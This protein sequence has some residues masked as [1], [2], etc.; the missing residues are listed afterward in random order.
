MNR[1][2]TETHIQL[3][4]SVGDGK[5]TPLIATEDLSGCLF[6][7]H[8]M[9]G[10]LGSLRCGFEVLT[11]RLGCRVK[12]LLAVLIE[13]LNEDE[14]GFTPNAFTFMSG[15]WEER[16]VGIKMFLILRGC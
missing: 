13:I 5:V 16:L 4:E 1:K 3:N 14:T 8:R 12:V 6:L 7:S 11:D 9:S 10:R 2:N 15:N